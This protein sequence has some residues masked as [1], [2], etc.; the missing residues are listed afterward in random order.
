[1]LISKISTHLPL[2]PWLRTETNGLELCIYITLRNSHTA[3]YHY[4]IYCLNFPASRVSATPQLNF[5]RRTVIT[6][7]I[8]LNVLSA[9]FAYTSS[10]PFWILSS[11]PLMIL[12]I[13]AARASAL[14]FFKVAEGISFCVDSCTFP[15]GGIS[16]KKKDQ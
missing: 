2:P 4:R 12:I 6:R 5:S 16:A 13:S 15:S 10:S 9:V 14:S 7:R 1:M 3:H 8:V 11:C